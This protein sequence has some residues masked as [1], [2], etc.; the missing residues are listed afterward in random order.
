MSRQT[1]LTALKLLL[2]AAFASMVFALSSCA[3][4]CV[5]KYDCNS[6]KE[7]AGNN[8]KSYTCVDSKCVVC[9]DGA[10]AP[11]NCP[12]QDYTGADAGP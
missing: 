10:N 11:N 4:E 8:D 6:I 3:P 9:Q 5:D 7:Q 12:T 1:R 2:V